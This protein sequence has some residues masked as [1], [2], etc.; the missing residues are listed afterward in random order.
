MDDLSVSVQPSF[1]MEN[2]HRFFVLKV[3]NKG[4]IHTPP[5]ENYWSPYRRKSPKKK[6]KSWEKEK[7]WSLELRRGASWRDPWEPIIALSAYAYSMQKLQKL[8]E[9]RTMPVLDR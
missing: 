3:Q 1:L 8:F 2:G 4:L 9:L 5:E 6:K 7:Q